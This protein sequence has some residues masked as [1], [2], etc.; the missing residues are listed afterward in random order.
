MRRRGGRP[1]KLTPEIAEDILQGIRAG[2]VRELAA[3]LAGI[4]VSTLRR[5]CE[6]GERQRAGP[7][8]DLVKAIREAERRTANAAG[9]RIQKGILDGDVDAAFRYLQSRFPE[10]YAPRSLMYQLNH[11]LRLAKQDGE[12]RETWQRLADF[13]KRQIA[14]LKPV[15]AAVEAPEWDEAEVRAELEKEG[16]PQEMLGEFLDALRNIHELEKRAE[17][18]RKEQQERPPGS[19]GPQPPTPGVPGP[20]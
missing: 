17:A 6:R 5:W 7:Y 3:R 18:R 1:S 15:G 9:A 11:L 13:V 2:H 4:D 16:I 14:K 12:H 10:H 8:A 20:A 19:G